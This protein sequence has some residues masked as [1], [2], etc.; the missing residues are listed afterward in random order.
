MLTAGFLQE[1]RD[2]RRGNGIEDLRTRIVA[3]QQSGE[4][5]ILDQRHGV[6]VLAI[7]HRDA[8]AVSEKLP[9]IDRV[10]HHLHARHQAFRHD[11]RAGRLQLPGGESIAHDGIKRQFERGK[12]VEEFFFGRFQQC[13][14]GFVID[15]LNIGGAFFA[16]LG[17]LKLHIILI[18]DQIRSDQHASLG[19]NSSQSAL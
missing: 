11:Q 19:Q 9:D 1:M 13:Q 15:H 7:L 16:G 5:V 8:H 3:K 18:G 4:F 6:T 17:A 14:I 10:M 12:S 2:D